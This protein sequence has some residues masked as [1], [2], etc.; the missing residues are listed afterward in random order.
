VLAEM[1]RCIDLQNTPATD[2][3]L[4]MIW[5]P[6]NSLPAEMQPAARRWILTG[7]FN[8]RDLSP[9]KQEWREWLAKLKGQFSYLPLENHE[10]YQA[11][12]LVNSWSILIDFLRKTLNL[13]PD[14]VVRQWAFADA[15][16]QN[17]GRIAIF[18]AAKEI[19]LTHPALLKSRNPTLSDIQILEDRYLAYKNARKQA[20]AALDE[21][22]YK[23][24][25]IRT[26]KP[27]PLDEVALGVPNP[28][29][30]V[31]RYLF[32]ARLDALGLCSPERLKKFIGEE[33]PNLN[34][35]KRQNFYRMSL[36]PRYGKEPYAALRV[37]LLD[38]RPVFEHK[39]FGWQ[40][41]DV[42]AAADEKGIDCPRTSLKQW[43]SRNGLKLR[44]KRGPSSIDDKGIIRSKPL[45]SPAPV[46]GDVLK[47]S[48][49]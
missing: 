45:L 21:L 43:A 48:S 22:L 13:Y 47:E 10:Y 46:F 8:D 29:N 1:Q 20:L 11:F 49:A 34:H 15:D 38:N 9:L 44:L 40:W 17:E 31:P 18:R 35:E 36:K 33:L 24:P 5:P 28:P 39:Q 25:S 19:E 32:I 16:S 4:A 37:W 6:W 7:N 3:Q 12:A 23:V 30:D 42:Q 26:G 41:A 14:L 27:L 2:E